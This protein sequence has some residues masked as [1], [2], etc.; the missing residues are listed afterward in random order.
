MLAH[1]VF[2]TLKESTPE[3][4]HELIEGCH[5][6]LRNHIGAVFFAVGSRADEMT[7][8]V[9]D[10]DFDVALTV[11]F[12]TA[13]DHDAYQ[14]AEEHLKFTEEHRD[15]WAAVRVFDAHLH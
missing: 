15:R 8:D 2:F 3:G 9:N 6:Y 12:A 13:E 5:R 1:H 4:R 11:V 7:R 10:R 14:K